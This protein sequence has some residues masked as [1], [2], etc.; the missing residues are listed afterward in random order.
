MGA[1]PVRR[2]TRASKPVDRFAVELLGRQ[3]LAQERPR[4]RQDPERPFRPGRLRALCQLVERAGGE[5]GLA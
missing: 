1:G 3:A 4:A 5:V 2:K